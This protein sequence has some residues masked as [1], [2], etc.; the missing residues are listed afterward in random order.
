MQICNI[1]SETRML[2][3]NL[4][5]GLYCEGDNNFSLISNLEDFHPDPDL[6]TFKLTLTVPVYL[7]IAEISQQSLFM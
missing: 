1:A 7:N 3:S 5:R 2:I 4:L 6:V